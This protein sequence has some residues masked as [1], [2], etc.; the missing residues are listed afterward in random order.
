LPTH[1]NKPAWRT[2]GLALTDVRILRIGLLGFSAGLPLLLVFGTLSFWLREAGIDRSTIGFISWIALAYA[3]KVFWSPLVD[4]LPLPGLTRW[5]GRR[6]AWLFFTQVSILLGLLGMAYTD[7]A[8]NL[9]LLIGLALWV[10]ISSATQ[11]L[12]IDAYRI[13]IADAELQ[14]ILAGVYVTGYRLAMLVSSGG[15]LWIAA[16]VDPNE[17]LYEHTTWTIAYTA[18]AACMLPGLLTTWFAPE[19]SLQP[20][21]LLMAADTIM[22]WPIRLQNWLS[23]A[24]WQPFADFIQRYGWLALLILALIASY[25]MSDIVLGIIANVFYKDMGFAKDE[26]ALVAKGFGIYMTLL[27]GLIGGIA[28]YRIGVMPMLLSGAVLAAG[29]NLLFMLLAT[30]G[31]DFW[32]FVVVIGMDNLSAGLA[33]AAFIAY[34]SVLTNVAYSATQYALFSSLMLLL[35]KFLG[36]FS[37]AFVDTFG[38]TDFFMLTAGLGIP[39]ILLVL[40]AWRYTQV[41]L[42]PR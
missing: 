5:L 39:V 30:A 14:G 21:P 37:G 3:L 41:I 31:Y 35:P 42:P 33:S 13:E 10:A 25:R 20:T 40:L 6:R 2:V 27:G 7:P 26:I 19:P 9:N 36:G 23:H 22:P 38:Y 29:T 28:V 8:H 4:H 1:F 34:L 16:L 15:V 17:A 12:V 32:L 18:M 11:D 24:I